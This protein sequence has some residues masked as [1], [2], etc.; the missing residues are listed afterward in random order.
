MMTLT[1]VDVEVSLR[2]EMKSLTLS[3]LRKFAENMG[4]YVDASMSR[5]EIEDECVFVEVYAF[6]H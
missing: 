5:E 6:T 4:V 3:Q 1:C 2:E